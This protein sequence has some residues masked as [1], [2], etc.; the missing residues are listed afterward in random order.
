MMPMGV[1]ETADLL[2]EGALT[3]TA[4]VTEALQRAEKYDSVLGVY[5]SR[6]D[7]AALRAAEMADRELA[8]GHDRGP[9]HG[10]PLGVK[11]LISTM[12]GPT[13]AQ[14]LVSDR[15]ENFFH[16]AISVRR[17]RAAGAIVVGKT[18]LMEFGLG[19][20]DPER[21]FPLPRNPWDPRRW[22]GGSSSGSAAGVAAG[23]FLGALGT[24]TGGSIRA[25]AA[26]CGVTGLKATYGLVP[27]GGCVGLAE[28]LDHLGPIARSAVDCAFVLDALTTPEP[29]IA[30]GDESSRSIYVPADPPS[31]D[32]LRLGVVK[33]GHFVGDEE[34]GIE[35]VFDRVVEVL[36]Q[37]G[38]SV[39]EVELPLYQ[40][41]GAA[42]LVTSLAEGCAIHR[43]R[44]RTQWSR[45][46]S[47]TREML[48]WG[49]CF[50][51]VDYIQAQR[52]RGAGQAALAELYRSV[53]VLLTP[54]ATMVAPL[55]DAVGPETDTS[56][57]LQRAHTAF[58]NAVGYP[59]ISIPIGF[60]P[61]GMPLG[62]QIAAPPFH[63]KTLIRVGMAYQYA[64][65]WHL[66][67][68]PLRTTV[69][70]PPREDSH[71]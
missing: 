38:A 56:E 58:W 50:S 24:D 52:V 36:E 33:S 32:G 59:V 70:L 53:D 37:L 51:A 16:D 19:M 63:E 40:E 54:T 13:T 55:L 29:D 25:P 27:L 45:Y 68:A 39:R 6:Y 2:R 57:L 4:I 30:E 15:Q 71:G 1:I 69:D 23:F 10:L 64:T 62:G 26:F 28:S 9:L 60:S 5:I 18:S 61:S 46:G 12:D 42:M 35:E 65:K 44:L 47:T 34:P 21:P 22:A 66:A 67:S 7:E 20:P 17:L 14:S 48:A 3:S 41:L 11:D 31:L 8:S 49:E 43:D